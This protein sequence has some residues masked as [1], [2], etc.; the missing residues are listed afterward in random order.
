MSSLS[1]NPLVNQ[2]TSLETIL[3]SLDSTC[4]SR[5]SRLNI[6]GAMLTSLSGSVDITKDL[7]TMGKLK[8]EVEK[9]KVS[10]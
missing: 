1:P 6:D 4:L 8:R 7:K 9:A 5:G 10:I 3:W 2:A